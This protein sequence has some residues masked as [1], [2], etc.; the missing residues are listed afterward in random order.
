[1]SEEQGGFRKD[2]NTVQQI[3]TLRL[4][5]EKHLEREKMV[6]H[7]FVDYTKAFDSVWHDGLW[8]VLE[9]YQV[10]QRLMKLMKD[11][12][13]QS[14]LAVKINGH[15]GEWFHPD[16]GSRQGDPLS[17]LMFITLLKR[18]M[19]PV[20]CGTGDV[21]INIHGTLV[22]DLRFADDVD[23]LATTDKDLQKLI[24]TQAG[25]SDCYGL[26]VNMKKTKVMKKKQNKA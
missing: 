2:R 7:C 25:S 5:S 13:N 18:V 4:I 6:Y 11:L 9:S 8:T 19:E 12:Y 26:K 3:L 14:E 24:S 1:M 15:L 20:E 17:P 16:V 23:L 10:P 21:G 22:K